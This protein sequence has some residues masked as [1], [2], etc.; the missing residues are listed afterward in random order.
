MLRKIGNPVRTELTKFSHEP[1]EFM[2]LYP[3]FSSGRAPYGREKTRVYVCCGR[4]TAVPDNGCW[5]GKHSNHKAA[6]DLCVLTEDA[7][8]L[9]TVW[10]PSSLTGHEAHK[11]LEK[12][13]ND[14]AWKDAYKEQYIF[15][16]ALGAVSDTFCRDKDPV[17]W[18]FAE[19][20]F[21]LIADVDNMG[22]VHPAA[23]KFRDAILSCDIKC[24][25][26]AAAKMGKEVSKKPSR[27]SA[28]P[29]IEE[30]RE[31]ILA[32]ASALIGELSKLLG[33]AKGKSYE[34]EY[35]SVSEDLTKQLGSPE[36]RRVV[37]DEYLDA[38][39]SHLKSLLIKSLE[40]LNLPIPSEIKEDPI[41]IPPNTWLGEILPRL[42][43][44]AEMRQQIGTL[45]ETIRNKSIEGRQTIESNI[46][47]TRIGLQEF[48]DE[49]DAFE[50]TL[51]LD[52]GTYEKLA[53]AY[54][55]LAKEIAGR[56]EEAR[57]IPSSAAFWT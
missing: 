15:N 49:L 12:Y 10:E 33:G 48:A 18:K 11:S 31:D 27:P 39:I 53:E 46:E 24:W 37:T 40:P 4:P 42:N 43:G 47:D 1:R 14:R 26:I 19:P 21:G 25:E 45:V 22:T 57:K 52:V 54:R 29:E 28:V 55:V 2:E 16:S 32:R 17:K 5:V 50:K 7:Q 41:G 20:K 3:L 34:A 13:I 9:P 44:A 36:G 51:R 6:P 38:A 30:E 8:I 23:K 56:V 35:R